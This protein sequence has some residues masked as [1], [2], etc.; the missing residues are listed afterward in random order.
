VGIDLAHAQR[1]TLHVVLDAGAAEARS[2]GGTS[3][4]DE[5]IS[6]GK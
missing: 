4:T 2:N 1:A 3:I 5:R 6:S